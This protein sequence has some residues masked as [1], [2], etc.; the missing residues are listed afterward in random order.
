MKTIHGLEA[1]RAEALG[2]KEASV[3]IGTF[4]G[5]HL[6][7]RKLVGAGVARARAGGWVSSG[8]TWDLSLIHI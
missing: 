2:S 1:L 7:H 3:V 4:D 8:V 5:V 6:G